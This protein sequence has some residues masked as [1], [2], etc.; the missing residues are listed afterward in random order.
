MSTPKHPIVYAGPRA[1]L[2]TESVIYVELEHAKAVPAGKP[3]VVLYRV[4]NNDTEAHDVALTMSAS[5]VTYNNKE[6]VVLAT[7]SH[8]LNL[9]RG[10]RK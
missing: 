7:K 4:I 1:R 6:P 2:H 9:S 10:A 5:S 3:I 8:K